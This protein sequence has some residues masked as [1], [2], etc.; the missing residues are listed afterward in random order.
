VF[1]IFQRFVLF[2]WLGRSFDFGN[3]H[4]GRSQ[5]SAGESGQAQE[6]AP[7]E[8]SMIIIKSVNFHCQISFV[9]GVI[10]DDKVLAQLS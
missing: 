2:S 5:S 3:T 7:G 4:R 10:A 1:K 6:L 9:S 8:T